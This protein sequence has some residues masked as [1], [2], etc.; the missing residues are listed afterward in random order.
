V[1]TSQPFP[2]KDNKRYKLNVNAGGSVEVYYGSNALSG[3]EAKSIL[4]CTDVGAGRT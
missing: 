2:R 3:K 1:K 4:S